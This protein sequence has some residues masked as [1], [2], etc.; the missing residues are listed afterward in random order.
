MILYLSNP[1]KKRDDFCERAINNY[2]KCYL[3]KSELYYVKFDVHN[4]ANTIQTQENIF[5]PRSAVIF[6]IL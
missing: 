3:I 2:G 6:N 1:V 4:V 5:I